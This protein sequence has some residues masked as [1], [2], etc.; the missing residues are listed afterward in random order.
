MSLTDIVQKIWSD[1][2]ERV[3]VPTVGNRITAATLAFMGATTSLMIVND[4]PL[5]PENN[6]ALTASYISWSFAQLCGLLSLGLTDC[7]LG[8]WE[9]YRSTRRRIQ[10]H[11]YLDE[12]FAKT[13]FN[14]NAFGFENELKTYNN[15][16]SFVTTAV[17]D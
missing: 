5:I 9:I 8:T 6:L 10:R 13:I 4:T 11:G 2:V 15:R 14:G 17:Y 1:R 16:D 3:W 12:S 7:G